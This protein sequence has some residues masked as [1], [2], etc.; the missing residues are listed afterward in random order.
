MNAN[1]RCTTIMLAV[2]AASCAPEPS[3]PGLVLTTCPI[4]AAPTEP[5]GIANP[6]FRAHILPALQSSCGIES[7][8][9]HGP[10]SGGE[11]PKGKIEWSTASGR[12]ADDVYADIVNVA[13]AN[14]PPGYM[15]VKASTPP[16][17]SDLALSWLYVKVTQDLSGDDGYGARM[18]F[19]VPNLCTATTDTLAAWITQGAAP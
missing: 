12:T 18:P 19:G 13:P 9:C 5:G 3:D 11:L 16:D 7:T 15:L 10:P 17:P 2:A 1:L 4:T 8:T 14:G 6:T